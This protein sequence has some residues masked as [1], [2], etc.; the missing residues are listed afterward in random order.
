MDYTALPV[1]LRIHRVPRTE[2]DDL[3][4]H[5]RIMEAETISLRETQ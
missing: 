5:L 1:V 2:W 4:E 3:F